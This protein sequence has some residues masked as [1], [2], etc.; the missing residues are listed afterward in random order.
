[1]PPG[2]TCLSI[3]GTKPGCR[4]KVGDARIEHDV[5]PAEVIE[6]RGERG[7]NHDPQRGLAELRRVLSDSGQLRMVEH[8]RGEGFS[9]RMQDFLQPAWT[10]L[11]GG[12]RPNRRTE[13]AVESAGF[14]I[15]ADG[16]RARD[17]FRRFAAHKRGDT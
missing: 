7:H 12:C 6:R 17:N 2:L 4:R 13:A 5:V 8:V 9:G 11:A 16:R 14:T 10:W 1:M 15:D 3:V